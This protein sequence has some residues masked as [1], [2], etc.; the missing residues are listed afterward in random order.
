MYTQIQ[1]N[2]GLTGHTF[3]LYVAH[4]AETRRLTAPYNIKDTKRKATGVEVIWWNV[5]GRLNGERGV[6]N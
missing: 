4:P 6:T 1:H 5:M 2:S 3:Y